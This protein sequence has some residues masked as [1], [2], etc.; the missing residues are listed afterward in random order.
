MGWVILLAGISLISWMIELH[1]RIYGFENLPHRNST[2][3]LVFALVLTMIIAWSINR[4]LR[5]EQGVI[6]KLISGLDPHLDYQLAV[7]IP[8]LFF[9]I[10]FLCSPNSLHPIETFIRQISLPLVVYILLL[11]IIWITRAVFQ[12]IPRM[13]IGPSQESQILVIRR[14]PLHRAA[15]VM[16]L[17]LAVSNLL[18][19]IFISISNSRTFMEMLASRFLVENETSIYTYASAMFLGLIAV[20]FGL[21]SYSTSALRLRLTWAG[22]GCLFLVFSVDEVIAVHEGLISTLRLLGNELTSSYFVYLVPVGLVI[23]FIVLLTMRVIISN[24]IKKGSFLILGFVMLFGGAV[25]IESITEFLEIILGESKLPWLLV[26]SLLFLEEG[27]E[28]TG[29]YLIFFFV[30]DQFFKKNMQ[31]HIE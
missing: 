12:L 27:L 29:T 13:K 16:F 22:L 20:G 31:L 9:T 14:K 10:L 5:I 26:K 30:M 25:F 2:I 8:I 19:S 4:G 17:F 7:L 28:L 6:H 3:V 24:G 15:W 1:G 18:A 21:L 23:L 11:L